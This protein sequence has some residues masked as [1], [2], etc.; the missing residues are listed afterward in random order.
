[1]RI[2]WRLAAYGGL[3]AAAAMF[4][5]GLALTLLARAAAPDDQ[6]KT[7]AET[8]TETAAELSSATAD[9]LSAAR[10]VN[11]IDLTTS[12]DEFV[13]IYDDAG[14]VRYTTGLVDGEA[15]R[16]PAAVIV[17]AL[18]LGESAA[19]ITVGDNREIRIAAQRMDLDGSPG[20]AVAGQS[21]A[22]IDEQL[23]GLI[24]V[25]WIAAILTLIFSGVVSWLVSGRALRPLGE[26]AAT[27]D[28]IGATGDLTRRLPPVKTNDEVGTLTQSFN[29]MLDRVESAQTDLEQSLDRQRRFVADASHELRSPLTTIRS[30]AGFLLDRPEAD[31]AD[32]TEAIAD[33]EA[34]AG[35]MAR[36]VDDLLVLA[37]A[38]SGRPLER[39]AVDLGAVVRDLQRRADQLDATVTITAVEPVVVSGDAAALTRLAWILIDNAARHG[40]DAIDVAVSAAEVEAHLTV[41]DDGAG[42]PSDEVDRVFDRFYRADPARSPAGAGLGL[43]IAREIAE[44]HGGTVT[45]SNQIDGGARV[46]VVIP[47]ADPAPGI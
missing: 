3:V 30:N 18:E 6:A 36:L 33:I 17:E 13:A 41:T 8:A 21:T 7:L 46:D 25:V 1:M 22:F 16:L 19:T 23:G 10:P 5:F 42:F 26:L 27:T 44:V 2:R 28:E 40:G 43:A 39:Y 35:R 11:Q 9:E 38:D 4:A 37:S 45:A 29:Q 47:L 14:T 34:E 32:R 15:P 20:V 24:A 12:S 31:P